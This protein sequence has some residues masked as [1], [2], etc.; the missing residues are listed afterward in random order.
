M[1]TKPFGIALD[2]NSITT[3]GRER[4]NK[5]CSIEITEIERWFNH[6]ITNS[7][8]VFHD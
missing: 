7:K 2:P 3:G 1:D 6:N 5:D 8:Y 4:V